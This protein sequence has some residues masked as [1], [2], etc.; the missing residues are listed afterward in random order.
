METRGA[1]TETLEEGAEVA[2]DVD[3]SRISSGRMRVRSRLLTAINGDSQRDGRW[4]GG[5]CRGGW[6]GCGSRQEGARPMDH[7]ERCAPRA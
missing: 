5:C 4:I 2:E 1:P 7:G 3:G 6:L